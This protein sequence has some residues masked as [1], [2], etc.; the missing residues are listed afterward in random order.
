MTP[1]LLVGPE[2]HS[3]ALSASRTRNSM[4]ARRNPTPLGKLWPVLLITVTFALST[5]ASLSTSSFTSAVRF[6]A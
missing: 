4:K 2:A 1:D 5:S 6:F 3:N